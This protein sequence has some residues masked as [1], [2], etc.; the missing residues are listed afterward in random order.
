MEIFD[1]KLKN[2][3][4]FY[5]LHDVEAILGVTQRTLYN[6]IKDGSLQAVKICGRWKV[7][8]EALQD[9]IDRG[10]RKAPA[11]GEGE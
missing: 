6:K 1:E 5:E 7:S 3:P 8:K 2:A 9:F 10:G 4:I 11:K